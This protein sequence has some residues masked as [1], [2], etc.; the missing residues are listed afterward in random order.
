MFTAVFGRFKG[1]QH[2]TDAIV[3]QKGRREVH[4]NA[5]IPAGA[6]DFGAVRFA[7]SD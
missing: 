7:R 6:D 2:F 1:V 3:F 4:G 5:F